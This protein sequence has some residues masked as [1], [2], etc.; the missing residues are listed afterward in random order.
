MTRNVRAGG[1][2][3]TINA[4]VGGDVLANVNTLHLGNGAAIQGN[5]TYRSDNQATVDSGAKVQGRLVRRARET[6][7][8]P[9]GLQILFGWLRALVGLFALGLIVVLVVPGLSQRTIA[10]LRASPWASLGLG[11][12][13]LIA[14]P[15]VALAV[16]V[17]GII[18]GAGGWGCSCSRRT[19]LR[20]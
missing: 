15:I 9:L 16:L 11:V 18:V 4:A 13:L 6:G 7:Q 1:G 19:P 14:V 12:L 3:L 2:D 8:P 10:T 17:A 5:V 20:W